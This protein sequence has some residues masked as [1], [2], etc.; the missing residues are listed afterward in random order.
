MARLTAPTGA[1]VSVA[2]DKADELVRRGF[3]V[4]DEPKKTPAKKATSSKTPSK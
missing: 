1:V 4:A 3:T 2:D